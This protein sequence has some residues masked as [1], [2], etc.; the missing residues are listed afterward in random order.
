[1]LHMFTGLSYEGWPVAFCGRMARPKL[2]C[3]RF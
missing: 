3:P 2:N 1:V